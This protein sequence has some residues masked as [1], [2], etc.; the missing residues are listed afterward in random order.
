MFLW[1]FDYYSNNLFQKHTKHQA[2]KMT[3]Q[4]YIQLVFIYKNKIYSKAS[5]TLDPLT[6]LSQIRTFMQKYQN[7][8]YIYSLPSNNE[9]HVDL[10]P[11]IHPATSMFH[12]RLSPCT[13]TC[14]PRQTTLTTTNEHFQ[15][16]SLP[17]NQW[18]NSSIKEIHVGQHG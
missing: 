6:N 3:H 11:S 8:D 18:A 4:I 15:S 12:L 5:S 13:V 16:P 1:L 17:H 7:F 2:Q 9:G 10:P 14:Q